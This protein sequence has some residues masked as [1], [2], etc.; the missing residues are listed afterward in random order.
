MAFI[1]KPAPGEAPTD[2]INAG[3]Y[4]LEADVLGRIPSG[5]RVSIERETFPSLVADGS[6]YALA[7]DA[8]WIDA[9]TPATYL[10]ANLALSAREGGGVDATASIDRGATVGHSVIGPGVAVQ[11]G[12]VVD[13]SV[14]LSGARVGPDA[15]VRG[16]IV[17]PNAVIGRGAVVEDLTV[18]GDGARVSAGVT[19]RGARVPELVS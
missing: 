2:L 18:L 11:A 13:G 19:L 15:A 4:V 8:E 17:G 14:V 3:T 9:G 5:R 6:V 7:S 12:A 10:E 1:E 16:S